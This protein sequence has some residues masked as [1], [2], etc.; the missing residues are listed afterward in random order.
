MFYTTNSTTIVV[1]LVR[2]EVW[3]IV[4]NFM[5]QTC[6]QVVTWLITKLNKQIFAQKLLNV[7]QTFHWVVPLGTSHPKN[8]IFTQL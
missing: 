2:K 5:K 7:W 6:V 4:V 8:L 3:A 1:G